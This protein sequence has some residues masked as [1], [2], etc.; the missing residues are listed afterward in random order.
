MSPFVLTL[1]VLVWPVLV[2]GVLAVLCTAFGREAAEARREGR[3][4]V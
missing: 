3:E 4:L 2:A 1:Y